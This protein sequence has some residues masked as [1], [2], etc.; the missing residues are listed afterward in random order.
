MDKNLEKRFRERAVTLGNCGDPA[1]LAEL[2]DLTRLPVA[3]VR[4][5]AASAIGKLAGLADGRDAVAALQPL[6]QDA[7]PQVRQYAAKALGAYGIQA[8]CALVDLRDMAISPVEK[9]YNNTC[10][11]LAIEL[12]EEATRIEERKAEHC[13]QRC[14]VKLEA[15]EFTRSKKAFQRP[16]CNYCFDEVFI[17]RRN[18]ETKVQL[19]KNIRAKDGT[20]VQSDGERLICEILNTE[21]IHYRYDERFRILDGYAI[22]PDFYLPEFDV[23]IEYWG[24][25]TADYK[26]GMLK[27]QQLYQQQGKRLLSLYPDDKPRIRHMLLEKLAKY[28]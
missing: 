26:I 13:C 19:Q 25:D 2:I 12:I 8:K 24:M 4:R 20:W 3:N 21:K 16:F 5:L 14:G 7:F 22:R 10:A 9:D 11:K 17:E 15:D 6:L 27:K 1:G 18:F 23:Y 28:K